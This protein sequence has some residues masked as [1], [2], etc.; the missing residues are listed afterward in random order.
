MIQNVHLCHRDE[1]L[2]DHEIGRQEPGLRVHNN[3]SLVVG[4]PE[5]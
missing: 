2:F 3:R 1:D 4:R 5:Y